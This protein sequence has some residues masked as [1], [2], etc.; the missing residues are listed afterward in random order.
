MNGPPANPISGMAPSSAT[1]LPTALVMNGTSSG[2]RARSLARSCSPRIGW[3]TT[4][5]TPGAMS[6]PT[7][8][9]FSGTTMSLNRIAASTAYRRSGCSVNSVIRSGRRAGFQHRRPGAG[10]AVLG[11]RTSRPGACTRPA[12]RALAAGSRRAGTAIPPS[13]LSHRRSCHTARPARPPR[14]NRPGHAAAGPGQR[15]ACQHQAERGEEVPMIRH[16]PRPGRGAVYWVDLV[17]C[18][19]GQRR[20]RYPRPGGVMRRRPRGP[21]AEAGGDCRAGCG[22]ETFRRAWP[23]WRPGWPRRALRPELTFEQEPA[24]RRLAPFAASRRP[25]P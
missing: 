23:A 22:R 3:S 17:S 25:S 4:G 6:M 12:Y 13:A 9:A 24:P 16:C 11:Q 8:T 18:V 10:R 20:T 14:G 21:L 5:P 2:C 7:P 1:R 15:A 19:M